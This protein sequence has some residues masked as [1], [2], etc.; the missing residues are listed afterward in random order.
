[1]RELK[2]T[3]SVEVRIVKSFCFSCNNMKCI[4]LS[5]CLHIWALCNFS[6]K[7]DQCPTPQV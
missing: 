7:E 3:V 4:C 2:I 1:M 6:G 5:Q